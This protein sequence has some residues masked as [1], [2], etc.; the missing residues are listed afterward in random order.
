GASTL[1]ALSYMDFP[2]LMAVGALWALAL[3]F[4]RGR[5]FAAGPAALS[6]FP[7][8]AGL[9]ASALGAGILPGWLRPEGAAPALVGAG[10]SALLWMRV[11]PG[12]R[13]QVAT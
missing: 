2:A 10:L 9:H 12:I 11:L 7:I 1:G 6:L 4:L 13:R 3:P 5:R 8:V